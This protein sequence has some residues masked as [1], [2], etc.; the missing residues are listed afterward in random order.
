MTD[1]LDVVAIQSCSGFSIEHNLAWYESQ[2]EQLPRI[3]PLVVV[4]P[5][6]FAV[7]GA[8]TGQPYREQSGKG[9]VQDW[10]AK[11]AKLH[12]LWLIGGSLPIAEDDK[13]HYQACLV[14]GPS[15]M[16]AARYDKR[17][18]F[19]VNISD[20]TG[21]YRESDTTYPGQS[22][23]TVTIE[24]FKV[25]L[26]I[27]YDLRFPEHFRG[28]NADVLVVPAAFTAITGEAHWQ[29]LLQARAIEN[30][31]YVV[32]ANQSGTH[33]NGRETWGHSM[34]LDP[35]GQ[36]SG[37]LDTQLGMIHQTLSKARLAQVRAS[38]PAL[39]HK[40]S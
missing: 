25:G 21:S 18:L 1:Q 12:E 5:E 17:H 16:Q 37:Q 8:P 14:Y 26:S 6:C 40:R 3:R 34:I 19:D 11:M 24:G 2:F 13:K 23:V 9:H 31:C 4:M 35:W 39:S 28:L 10:L 27:C 32:A 38:I 20:S 33:E 22:S 36:V 7:F 29:P 15:G 30:Q